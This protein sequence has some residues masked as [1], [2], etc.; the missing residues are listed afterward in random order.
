MIH[1]DTSFAV[2]LMRERQRERHGP[3]TKFVEQMADEEFAISVFAAAELWTGVYR[4]VRRA[5]EQR[6]VTD[7]LGSLT[8]VMA[9]S[10]FPERYGEVAAR[11]AQGGTT[12]ATMDLLIGTVALVED[13]TLVTANEAHF[14]KVPGLRVIGY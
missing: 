14:S 6:A 3:A 8:V 10:R 2:D 4:S 9:D 7:L 12:V 1:L 13:A 5:H 11:L